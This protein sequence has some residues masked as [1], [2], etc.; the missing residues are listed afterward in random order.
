MFYL[1]EDIVSKDINNRMEVQANIFASNFL[2]PDNILNIYWNIFRIRYRIHQDYLFLHKQPINIRITHLFI[3][4]VRYIFG[5]SKEAAILKL[6]N[7]GI[8]V[9]KN[10]TTD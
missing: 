9:K 1:F 3:D 4:Y 10:Y 5:I 2:I 7:R 8:I 6:I